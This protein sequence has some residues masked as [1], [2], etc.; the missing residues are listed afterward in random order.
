VS[1]AR[2]EDIPILSCME[3]SK[4]D[5]H[6]VGNVLVGG[7]ASDVYSLMLTP[8]ILLNMH[9]TLIYYLESAFLA[10][11]YTKHG[12]RCDSVAVSNVSKGADLAHPGHRDLSSGVDW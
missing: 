7:M 8:N 12:A 3:Y 1:H 2:K 10:H 6:R 4:T 5:L 11:P 9:N